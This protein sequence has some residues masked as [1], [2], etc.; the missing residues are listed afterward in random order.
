[1]HNNFIV[2]VLEC[3]LFILNDLKLA[4]ISETSAF[5]I[6]EE[7]KGSGILE[8][9]FRPGNFQT[10]RRGLGGSSCISTIFSENHPFPS[11]RD[12]SG[13]AQMSLTPSGLRR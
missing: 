8:A 12:R 13:M 3:G 9:F 1:M 6:H 11:W 10:G 4:I 2:K 7:R 5:T